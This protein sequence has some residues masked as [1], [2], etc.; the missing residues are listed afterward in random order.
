M[1]ERS[2]AVIPFGAR[3]S[4]PRVGAWG[5]QLARRLVDRFV[6][7]PDL[8][9]RPVFLVALP[10]TGGDAAYLV[11]GATP[12]TSL[13]A[14][15]GA[16]LGTT[17]ALAGIL[18]VDDHERRLEVTLVDVAAQRAVRSFGSPYPDGT[19][20][21]AEPALAGWLAR[22]LA[23]TEPP[24]GMPAANEAAYSALLEGL[25]EEL[26]ATL[27]RAT[28][29]DRAD[30]ALDR[31]VARHLA[32]IAADHGCTPAEERLLVLAAESLERGDE[33]RLIGPL[34]TLSEARSRSWRAHYLLGELRRQHGDAAGA[35][36][37]L[38]HADA[39]HPLGDADAL[40]LAL[41]YRDQAAPRVAAARLRRIPAGSPVSAEA[42]AAL[43]MIEA[44]TSWE[45][46][47]EQA[48]S[49][50]QAGD[51]A[52]ARDRYREAVA[53]GAPPVARLNLARALV[54]GGDHAAGTAELLALLDVERG[55]E[56]AA[57][58]RR[59]LLGLR[60]PALER[61]LE[62]A[63][64][65]AV[66]GADEELAAAGAELA[67]ISAAEPDVWE[68][69]FGAGLIARRTGDAVAAER[70]FR[71][72]LAL[73][74]D[75]P[76]ALHELG[77]ALLMA[78]RTNEAVRALE[79]AARLRPADAGYLADAGFGQLRAGNL[80]AARERLAAAR[81]LE[82]AD[83]VTAAYWAELER[84]ERAVGTAAP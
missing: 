41:L 34:E 15:Y 51:L 2:I 76:D 61:R 23:T 9:L 75:Q 60:A 33:A 10:E 43:R 59:L 67:A 37:A 53:A 49:L 11:L 79:T 63:G 1:A 55:G 3:S 78:D 83:P 8:E 31:A 80:G 35:V 36:V 68:A 14:R 66:G 13:A 81:A 28:D 70:A 42:Q 48:M 16:T 44:G 64:R 20:H 18:S 6:G 30:A 21:L 72:V 19:L 17:H 56:I 74:P 5:R 54:A 46:T 58:A 73:W 12:D 32:A 22:A 47:L 57:Q 39:L 62:A 52:P 50:H 24:G 77:V 82:P 29:P 26:N 40:R 38:E 45:L 7:H 84:I 65:V 4:D 25:D 69:Q 27:L 71:R